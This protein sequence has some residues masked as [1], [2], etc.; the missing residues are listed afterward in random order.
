MQLTQHSTVVYKR[1][2]V[3]IRDGLLIY[4][5][6]LLVEGESILGRTDGI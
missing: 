6:E 1:S 5:K 4:D 2:A 3:V